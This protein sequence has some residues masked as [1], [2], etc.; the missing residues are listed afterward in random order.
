MFSQ[1][2][3]GSSS[4]NIEQPLVARPCK[5]S[6]DQASTWTT[7][8][9]RKRLLQSR[10]LLRIEA[11]EVLLGEMHN[12]RCKWWWT[13]GMGKMMGWMCFVMVFDVL[14]LWWFPSS[15]V[16]WSSLET[17][18]THVL[19]EH[20][21]LS[22]WQLR[23]WFSPAIHG[24]PIHEG[25]VTGITLNFCESTETSWLRHFGSAKQRSKNIFHACQ[26]SNRETGNSWK[27][28]ETAGH[29]SDNRRSGPFVSANWIGSTSFNS[30][31]V[32]TNSAILATLQ[33]V[34]ELVKL[35]SPKH[36]AEPSGWRWVLV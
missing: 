22:Q 7:L 3:F 9:L 10:L 13:P 4:R 15:I 6:A 8:Q 35:E 25:L 30:L 20:F 29:S 31:T 23:R 18:I 2:F 11:R 36:P 33:L 21:E 17:M 19:S 32:L 12:T 34:A 5:D 28:Q 1:L 16:V 24:S 14:F 26:R 27:Q